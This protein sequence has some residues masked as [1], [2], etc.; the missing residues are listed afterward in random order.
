MDADKLSSMNKKLYSFIEKLPEYPTIEPIRFLFRIFPI[1]CFF[2]YG[3]HD[4]RLKT[5]L[6]GPTKGTGLELENPVILAA[7]YELKIVEKSM[8]MGFGAGTAKCSKDPREGNKGRTIIRTPEGPLN[9]VGYRNPGMIA[10]RKY[11][12]KI[13]DRVSPSKGIIL[14]ISDSSIDNYCSV[15]DYMDDVPI[16]KAFETDNCLNS[17]GNERLDFFS[18]PGCANDLFRETRKSTEKPLILKL[19]RSEDCPGMHKIIETALDNGYT[20]LNYA[21]TKRVK[22]KRFKSGECGRSG[23]S[24]YEDTL[25]NVETLYLEFGNHAD[26]IGTG[27]IHS[28]ASAYLIWKKGAK[29]ISFITAFPSD[30]FL[31]KRIIG[32]FLKTRI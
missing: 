6:R 21:N 30:I 9:S 22:D 13:E 31:A 20:I 32:Y 10:T 5:V 2:G 12:E 3:V 18:D 11:M 4:E 26:I 7:G 25:E 27:G 16:I 8:K 24:L 14:N 19:P 17:P 29:G 23:P 15:I 1:E 28:P